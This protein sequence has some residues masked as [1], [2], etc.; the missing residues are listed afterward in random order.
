ML[1][2]K[3][4]SRQEL[5]VLSWIPLSF[6]LLHCPQSNSGSIY[7]ATKCEQAGIE[8]IE[9]SVQSL[10]LKAHRSSLSD[11]SNNNR[12]VLREEVGAG[13]SVP[14]DISL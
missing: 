14:A 8:S 13:K 3:G 4:A 10:L 6:S 12:S 9:L 5:I 7:F 1:R 11:I 2:S